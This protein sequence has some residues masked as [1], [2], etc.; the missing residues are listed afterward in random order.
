MK[1]VWSVVGL[2]LVLMGGVWILQGLNVLQV[3]FMA[4]H[5]EYAYLGAAVAVVGIGLLIVGNRRRRG[6]PPVSGK[7]NDR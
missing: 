3:G 7:S 6:T 1:W 2:V 5:M 4:G